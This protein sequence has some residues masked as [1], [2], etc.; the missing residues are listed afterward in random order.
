[1]LEYLQQIESSGETVLVTEDGRPTVE[2]RRY[3]SNRRTPL[4]KLRGSVVEF[5]YPT[6]TI[7]VDHWKI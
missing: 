4:V 3:Y 2:M 5:E 7:G 6:Q 1:M